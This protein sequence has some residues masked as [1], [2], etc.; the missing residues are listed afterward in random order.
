MSIGQDTHRLTAQLPD[1]KAGADE[2]GVADPFGLDL[3][4]GEALEAVEE[5]EDG[6]DDVLGDGGDVDAGGGG[7]DDGVGGGEGL[8]AVRSGERD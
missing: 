5:G 6:A 4:E 8:D 3:G 2:L 7:E 1:C